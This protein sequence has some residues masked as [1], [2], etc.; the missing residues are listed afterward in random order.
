MHQSTF[1][2]ISSDGQAPTSVPLEPNSRLFA[3]S[4][5]NCGLHL[6]SVDVATIH[7]LVSTDENQK[8]LIQDWNTHGGTMLNGRPV[9]GETEFCVGDKLSVGP[10][11]I[12]LSVSAASE[13]NWRTTPDLPPIAEPELGEVQEHSQPIEP[14]NEP[15]SAGESLADPE[16][17]NEETASPQPAEFRYAIDMTEDDWQRDEAFDLPLPEYDA[18][19]VSEQVDLLQLEI[20]QLHSELAQRDAMIREMESGSTAAWDS[21]T[22]DDNHDTLRLVN[23]LEELLDELKTS[24]SRVQE[25]EELLRLS[26]EATQAE[27]EE[28]QQLE[29]WVLEIEQRVEQKEALSEAE[30]SRVEKK[31]AELK[32]DHAVVQRQLRQSLAAKQ[33]AAGEAGQKLILDLREQVEELQ[34]RLT[35]A[36]EEHKKLRA[37]KEQDESAIRAE[38]QKLEQSYLELQVETSQER[39]KLAR[40]REQLQ[41]MQDQV[42]KKLNTQGLDNADTKIR[43]MRQH[44]NEARQ[45]EQEAKQQRSLGG[46]IAKL[47]SLS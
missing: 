22:G 31:Y 35:A 36:Q 20:E 8:V 30:F 39:A 23:R 9:E 47:L 16:A 32:S 34:F 21:S 7:F 25:L 12:A 14:V 2:N 43:A 6:D 1:L 13:P 11:Q 26:D 15:Q 18:T 37:Q 17:F 40:E 24:D 19:S 5:A 28:R 46:R 33:D 29:S 44:L 4:G 42:E 27:Q 38:L 41:R 45:Q 10:Y 3:G